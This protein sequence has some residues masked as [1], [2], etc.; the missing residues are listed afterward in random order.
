MSNNKNNFD[1]DLDEFVKKLFGNKKGSKEVKEVPK[2]N[3]AEQQVNSSNT[4]GK[5]APTPL[6]KDKK[7]INVKQWVSSA[8][9]LTVVF[10]A[11]IVVF[12]NLYIVKEN[13]YKVVRQ[14][15]EVVKY[16]SEPGLHMKIPFIQSVTTLPSN[17]M[18]HDMTEEEIS[19][20]DKKRI[21]IDNYTVWRVTDPKA[22]ISNAGQLLNAESRME[23]F[24]YSALRT[25][26]GQTE[27]GDIINEKD[28]K[29]GNINDRVTQRV[30]ELIDSANFGIEVIDVR[31]RRTDLPEENEQSV[32]TRMVSERQSI[33]QKYLSE[34]DAEKR[35]KEAKTD[36][37][38]QV[39]LAKAN[40]EASVIRAEGEAQAAQIYNA[41]YSKDPEFYS[42]FRTL[43]S[44]KKTIGNE[45]M[46]IIPSDSPYAKLLSG[47]LD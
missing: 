38:V 17:L 23:E 34:G 10:A 27:Y 20:K 43:E 7:P 2:A 12:A 4:N 8:I 3:D 26:F 15:G 5:K 44:Y 13:E 32:Y 33:A 19:T 39:T 6:K 29:R 24:I 40:K 25:E 46:I 28:S 42:L 11:L 9:V 21:I 31:I 30:N 45:T 47:R 35:S 22:L 36:Q 37:E 18:T 14:F 1:G 16:E 41:A